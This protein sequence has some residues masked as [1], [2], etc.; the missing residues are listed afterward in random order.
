VVSAEF[1]G[2][3]EGDARSGLRR[4]AASLGGRARSDHPLGQLTTYR[5]GGPAALYFE[6]ESEGDLLSVRRALYGAQVPVLVLGKGSNM[7]VADAGFP[8]LVVRLGVGCSEIELPTLA[9]GGL[10][11][12]GSRVRAGGGA[13]LPVLARRTVEAGLSGLEW[14]VGVP[15]SVGGAVR[16]N[17]GGHGAD[18]ASC[19]LRYR[20]LDLAYDAGGEDGPDRLAFG[21]RTSAV[22]DTEVVVWA[23]LGLV[24]GSV[25]EGREALAEIVR[26]RREH[27][28]GGSNAGSVFTNPPGDSAGRLVEVA[29]LKGYRMGSAQ[30]SS[31][32]ANFI[33]ADDGGSADDVRRLMEHVRQVVAERCGV[34]LRTEVRLVGFPTTDNGG[35]GPRDGTDA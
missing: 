6:A 29:G 12:Q 28:P 3:V 35:R 9:A 20:W 4:V 32:H 14:A 21:Y 17:A 34:V 30:V 5:V 33:Q 2:G 15:G 31:K 7:L 19:L 1:H 27:Q 18:A 8:G 24:R 23:E 25:E 22:L 13:S 11:G 16:M 10:G 26:W